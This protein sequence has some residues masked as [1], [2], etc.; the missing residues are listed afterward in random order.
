MHWVFKIPLL[1]ENKKS[2]QKMWLQ[3]KIKNDKASYKS[4]VPWGTVLSI[5]IINKFA[6]TCPNSY[7]KF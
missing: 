4:N 2:K 7:L 1:T 3:K 5:K 6:D